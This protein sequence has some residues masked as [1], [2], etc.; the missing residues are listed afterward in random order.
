[1]KKE[2]KEISSAIGHTLVPD[3]STE[4]DVGEALYNELGSLSPLLRSTLRVSDPS[5]DVYYLLALFAE[6]FEKCLEEYDEQ[7][8][9]RAHT[10][11]VAAKIGKARKAA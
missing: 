6:G 5:T 10:A 11:T 8:C 2:T 1:M 7:R 4:E 3:F 9:E